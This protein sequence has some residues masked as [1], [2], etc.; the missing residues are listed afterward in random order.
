MMGL[1]RTTPGI[2]RARSASSLDVVVMPYYQR[3]FGYGK[4]AW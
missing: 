1:I 2:R 3:R 4:A